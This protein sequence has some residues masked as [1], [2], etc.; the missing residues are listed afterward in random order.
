MNLV[1]LQE[2]NPSN[3]MSVYSGRAGACCCGCKGKHHYNSSHVDEATA[4]R[5]YLVT[6][7]EVNDSQVTRVLRLVQA[8]EPAVRFEYG[9]VYAEVGSR[10]YI[11]YLTRETLESVRR[12]NVQVAS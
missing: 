12:E 8:N 6:P 9:H 3:V 5:G 10:V 4:D 2:L 1:N 11:V 7:D